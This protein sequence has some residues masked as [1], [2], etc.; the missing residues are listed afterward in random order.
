MSNFIIT[1]LS[2]SLSGSI[3]ALILLAGK[4]FIKRKVSSV[5][6][7]YIWLLVLL[8]L[9][10]PVAS[11]INIMNTLFWMDQSS[12]L[13]EFSDSIATQDG[14]KNIQS[15]QQSNTFK[16]TQLD[17]QS[18]PIREAPGLNAPKQMQ[19]ESFTMEF[20]K[21]NLLWIWLVG[22][23][24]S[25]GWFIVAYTVFSRYIRRSCTA[26]H[27]DD[28]SVFRNLYGYEKVKLVCSSY[29]S[30]PMLI[31]IIRPV[32]I[33]PQFTY[34]HNGMGKELMN[35]LQHELTHYRRKDVLYKWF[36]I[37]VTSLHWFN[38]LMILIRREIGYACELSC[39]EVVIRDMSEEE[40][41]T[42]GNTL[43]T[44]AS[45]KK[46]PMGIVTTTLCEDKK[47][48]KERLVSIMK[49]KK[50][51]A[52][53]FALTVVLVLI[54]TGCAAT[55]GVARHSDNVAKINASTITD[56]TAYSRKSD[57]I[58]Y[59]WR[60]TGVSYYLGKDGSI[61]LSYDGADPVKA[62][63]V[64]SLNMRDKKPMAENTGF[65]ISNEMTAIAYGKTD[66][67]GPVTVIISGDR[68]KTWDNVSIDFDKNASW[69]NIGFTTKNN[70]W[71]IISSF[72]GMGQEQHYLYKTSDGGKSWAPVDGNINDVY[73]RMLSGASFIDDKIGFAGFR[74]ES[75]SQVVVYMTQDG[76]VTW[77][78][79]NIGLAEE[80]KQY[81][82]TPLSPA[83]NGEYVVLP[84]QLTDD[85]GEVK[86]VFM[87]S[88][89]DGRTWKSDNRLK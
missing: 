50:K 33:L 85:K 63:L 71:M 53:T 41:R 81:K 15:P 26:P 70:G 82:Q 88:Y 46:I 87:T 28:L 89:D 32:I 17:L 72:I 43:L 52:W 38:P 80:Y 76:G 2:L 73:I 1:I 61:M 19:K 31:G 7:Y 48:L 6:A 30:T 60:N 75:N 58:V 36:L 67:P 8:R 49:F 84:V 59:N 35:I 77:R 21:D 69:I 44:L 5:F 11:P 54:L 23:A 24:V 68:G 14:T 20:I 29:I 57:G 25:L 3:L 9:V 62:P 51:P 37:A 18:T 86:I 4:S 42:Y 27:L 74:Y 64:L 78:K 34:D 65:F 79:V 45:N 16:N 40:K 13:R 39:D 66:S 56:G 10:V 12:V 47:K 22:V 83:F 55:L